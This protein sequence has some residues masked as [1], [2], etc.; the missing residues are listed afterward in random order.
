MRF[1]V[2]MNTWRSRRTQRWLRRKGVELGLRS[3]YR[4]MGDVGLWLACLSQTATVPYAIALY[5]R[6][7]RH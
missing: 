1:D 5:K 6:L 7:T 4:E 2:G 3:S